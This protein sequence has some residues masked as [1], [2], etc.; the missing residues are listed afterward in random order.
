M[1]FDTFFKYFTQI[2]IVL[3]ICLMLDCF[4]IKFSKK[5]KIE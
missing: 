2:Y 1:D 3:L 5:N 4:R